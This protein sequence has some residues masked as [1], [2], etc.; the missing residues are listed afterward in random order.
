MRS[1]LHVESVTFVWKCFIGV[2]YRL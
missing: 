2:D 1:R